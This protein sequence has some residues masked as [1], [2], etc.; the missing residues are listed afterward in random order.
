VIRDHDLDRDAERQYRAARL[1][2]R[3]GL[4]LHEWKGRYR[5]VRPRRH[6][7]DY[8]PRVSGSLDLIE[9]VLARLDARSRHSAN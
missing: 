4:R 1:A 9:A 2:L 3:H 5:L 7:A 6:V 8:L